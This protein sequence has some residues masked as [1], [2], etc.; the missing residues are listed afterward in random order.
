MK[1]ILLIIAIAGFA[2]TA[3]SQSSEY[4]PFKVDIGLGYAIPSSGGN[5]TKGG[6]TF[7]IQPH[8]RLSDALALGL[9]L[10]GAAL[11]YENTTSS[12]EDVKVSVLASYCATGEYYLSNSG[13]RPFIGAG[14]GLFTQESMEVN[15]GGSTYATPATSKFGFFPEIG[16]ETGHFRMS[17]DYNILGSNSG[18]LAFKIGFFIGG[19][20]K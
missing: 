9:R 8:Y 2:L 3:R 13:F 14:A 11:G 6:V 5:S 10:E 15:T 18:Y 20:K 12:N 17:A 1:K 7:T 16:F 4:K 19:G